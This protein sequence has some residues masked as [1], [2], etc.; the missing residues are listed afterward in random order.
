M[1][2]R[3]SIHT[4][5]HVHTYTRIHFMGAHSRCRCECSRRPCFHEPW[6]EPSTGGEKEWSTLSSSL[7]LPLRTECT[8]PALHLQTIDQYHLFELLQNNPDLSPQHLHRQQCYSADSAAAAQSWAPPLHRT[9]DESRS[10][11]VLPCR[12]FNRRSSIPARLARRHP[13]PCTR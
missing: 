10:T 1:D 3:T 13:H 6:Q 2:T 9:G 4:Y 5:I 8:L 7:S 11:L 12:S